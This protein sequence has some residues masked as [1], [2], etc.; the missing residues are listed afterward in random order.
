MQLPGSD[1]QVRGPLALS[2]IM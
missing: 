2:D 1:V